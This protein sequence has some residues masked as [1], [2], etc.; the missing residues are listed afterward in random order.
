MIWQRKQ[1]SECKRTRPCQGH[2]TGSSSRCDLWG[3]RKRVDWWDMPRQDKLLENK[4]G[5]PAGEDKRSN[6]EGMEEQ[7]FFL[8]LPPTYLV[9]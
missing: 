4:G 6:T 2:K 5:R 9:L 7:A 3:G 1:K 8:T